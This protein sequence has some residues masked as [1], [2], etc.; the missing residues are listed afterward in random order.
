MSLFDIASRKTAQRIVDNEISARTLE[1]LPEYIQHSLLGYI[2]D[3]ELPEWKKKIQSV[4]DSD[5]FLE[6]KIM[7]ESKNWE[8]V[9]IMWNRYYD[10]WG[11]RDYY[12]DIYIK[13][14]DDSSTLIKDVEDPQHGSYLKIV[15][16]LGYNEDYNE[17]YDFNQDS[18]SEFVDS[19]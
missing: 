11:M 1:K 18:E 12:Q 9:E 13:Y 19:P 17:Y 15:N 4:V 2:M 5:Q 16:Q 7:M 10:E 8:S 3:L 6:K 14:S